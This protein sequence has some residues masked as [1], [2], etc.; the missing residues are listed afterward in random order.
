MMALSS[1]P[2]RVRICV[3]ALKKGTAHATPSTPRTRGRTVSRS[4]NGTSI[5]FTAASMTQMSASRTSLITLE[6]RA[7]SPKKIETC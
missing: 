3:V 4:G 7:S 1:V 5:V 2:W 6:A